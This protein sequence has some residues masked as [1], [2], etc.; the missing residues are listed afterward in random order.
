MKFIV[1]AV[2]LFSL[3]SCGSSGN[4]YKVPDLNSFVGT[5]II[6]P[7]NITAQTLG[8]DTTVDAIFYTDAKVL[9]YLDSLGCSSCRAGIDDWKKFIDETKEFIDNEKLSFLIYLS[10]NKKSKR[11]IHYTLIEKDFDYPVF[12]DLGYEFNSLNSNIPTSN[13]SFIMF[14]LD[15]QNRV[16]LAGNPVQNPQLWER[17]K[18]EIKRLSH[19]P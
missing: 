2:I 13:S 6:L 14:L 10:P 18:T 9:I 11:A 16:V 3:F 4:T 15:R 5:E 19:N 12:M 17:Y 7:T 1:I 8:R